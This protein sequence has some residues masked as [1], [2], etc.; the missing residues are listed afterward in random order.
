M[1]K[2]SKF[3]RKVKRISKMNTALPHIQ[4]AVTLTGEYVLLSSAHGNSP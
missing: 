4:N 1:K 3:Y 2:T